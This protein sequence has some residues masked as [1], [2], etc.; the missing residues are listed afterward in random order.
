MKIDDV[1]KG[2]KEKNAKWKPKESYITILDD[3]EKRKFLGVKRP[4]QLVQAEIKAE[5]GNEM[6]DFAVEVDWR[7]SDQVTPIKNQGPC[8][9]CVAFATVAVM[10]SMALIEKS[11]MLDLSEADLFYCSAHGENCSGW[12]PS[13][14]F[15]SVKLRG[16]CDEICSPYTS[17]ATC[18]QCSNR[19]ERAVKG[20]TFVKLLANSDIKNYLST[21]GPLTAIMAIYEDFYYYKTGIFKH[22]TGTYQGL[23]CIALVGYS[24]IEKCWI[25]KNSWG[26]T[27]G[28]EGFFKLAYGDSQIDVYEKNGVFGIVLPTEPLPPPPPIELLSVFP[29][30]FNVTQIGGKVKV[31]V[32]S[33]TTWT[34]SA[35]AT[36]CSVTPTSGV[37][38]GI[39][40]IAYNSNFGVLRTANITIKSNNVIILVQL[41]QQKYVKCVCV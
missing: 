5:I 25:C 4:N 15:D 28:D 21:M 30:S 31:N 35:S 24:E 1:K 41:T 10:E 34:A 14:A 27:W 12:W 36:W 32:S 19:D 9:S 2:I 29:T 8:G 13:S 22:V 23:H 39:L 3:E 11:T 20:T 33:N 37:D 40:T 16:V 17:G 7:A 18:V 38:N 6:A 26:T